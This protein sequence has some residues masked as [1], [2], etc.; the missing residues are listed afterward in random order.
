MQSSSIA[1]AISVILARSASARFA[2]KNIA[3]LGPKRLLEWVI[4]AALGSGVIAKVYV[5]TDSHQYADIARKAGA[6]PIMRPRELTLDTSTPEDAMVHALDYANAAGDNPRIAALLQATTPLTKPETVRRAVIAVRN[7]F[8]TSISIFLADK[9]PWWAL[10][11]LADGTLEPFMVLPKDSPYNSQVT[12][13][14]YYPT[15]GVYAFKTEFFRKTRLITGG[16]TCGIPTEWFE[17]IDIDYKHDLDF[18]RFA[19]EHLDLQHE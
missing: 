9:K 7:G 12:P 10:K 8:D 5:S 17:A 4:S 14:V 2:D 19:L 3:Y 11:M 1:D 6:V 16:R 15:G 18:A 13:P